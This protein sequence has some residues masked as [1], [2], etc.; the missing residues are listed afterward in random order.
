MASRAAVNTRYCCV[1][2][3]CRARARLPN[4]PPASA[5][6]AI[7]RTA[8][9]KKR[10]F[11][12]FLD[13][14][15]RSIGAATTSGL[16]GGRLFLDP[17]EGGS[18]NADRAHGARNDRA[19]TLSI[20]K[21]FYMLG[22]IGMPE[23]III[24]VIALIIFGPRKL[25]ELGRSLGKSINEFKRASNELKNTLDEEIR[26]EE[27]RSSDR[28]RAAGACPSATGRS[29]RRP[30]G[31]SERSAPLRRRRVNSRYGARA[32]SWRREAGARRRRSAHPSDRSATSSEDSGAK[33]SFLD[34][35]DELRKRLI[36][37]V[38]G[39]VIGCVDRVLFRR[40]HSGLHLAP[41]L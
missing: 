25:P 10:G 4:S 12:I 9:G 6:N 41:A 24:F 14:N 23:L 15:R 30:S 27:Q 3:S 38:W 35:L 1:T 36:A 11:R 18:Y 34:H 29:S 33:M 19:L 32:L 13:R 28:Q 39:L 8:T 2:S 5:D 37:C 26:V 16:S 40:P 22:S 21:D 31:R 17:P 7:A 20:F